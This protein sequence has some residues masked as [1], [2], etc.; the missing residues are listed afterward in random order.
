M[1]TDDDALMQSLWL[2]TFKDILNRVSGTVMKKRKKKWQL[3]IKQ[4]PC[5]VW[6][7]FNTLSQRCYS[8]SDDP[9]KSTDVLL[10]CR[11][12]NTIPGKDWKTVLF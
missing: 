8:K 5:I 9:E 7:F 4:L 1:L 6:I 12:I 3:V 10:I 2:G 11:V